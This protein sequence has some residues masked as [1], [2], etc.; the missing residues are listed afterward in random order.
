MKLTFASLDF[1]IPY[2]DVNRYS[3]RPPSLLEFLYGKLGQ[4]H[5]LAWAYLIVYS[6]IIHVSNCASN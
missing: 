3:E 5:S 4:R 1:K 6:R 2:G